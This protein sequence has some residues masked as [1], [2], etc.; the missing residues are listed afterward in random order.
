M[1]RP[2]TIGDSALLDVTFELIAQSGPAALTFAAAAKAVGLAPATLVQRFGTK[3]RLIR[4]SLLHAWDD[5][6]ARTAAADAAF[7]DTPH[8]AVALLVSLS[9]YGDRET[10]ANGL[11]I[12]REDFRDPQLRERGEQWGRD[13]ASI[14]GRRLTDDPNRQ[15][16]FGRMMANQWQGA[17]LW[18]GFARDGAIEEFV[19]SQLQDFVD[20]LLA[21]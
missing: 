11:V 3:E 16:S 1:P 5:V 8:G 21:S 10:Y 15:L 14:L 19:R 20:K 18:W 6:E 7:P 4:A 9:N 13:L 2:R 17:I 12:L